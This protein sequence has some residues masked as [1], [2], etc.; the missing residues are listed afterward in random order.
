MKFV[1]QKDYPH[2][3]YITRTGHEG[4]EFEKGKTTTIAT[5]GCGLCGAVMMAD[6]LIPNC[7]FELQD[8]LDLSY[9]VKGNQKKGTDYSIYGPALAEKLNLQYKPSKDINDVIN[10]LRTG[11]CAIVIAAGDRDGREGVFCH[12][13][14]VM[15]A[16][17][18]DAD[19]RLVILD[20]SFEPT[21]YESDYRKD[22]VEI[23]NG[24]LVLTKPVILAEECAPKNVPYHL[25]W[26]K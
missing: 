22:K 16:I 18:I 14:H 4:E 7:T 17:S 25:Y 1:C 2:W 3:L 15:T 23:K 21:K 13:G 12:G 20:P 26:R 11:G 10:C 24:Y 8:A 9:A 6:Q 19:G 5:S